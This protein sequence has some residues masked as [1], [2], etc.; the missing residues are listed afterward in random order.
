[1]VLLSADDAANRIKGDKGPEAWEPP[2]RDYWCEYSRRWIWIKSEWHLSINPTER[3]ALRQ[4]LGT[5][6]GD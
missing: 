6:G 4:M 2:N 3:S 1:M 5:C